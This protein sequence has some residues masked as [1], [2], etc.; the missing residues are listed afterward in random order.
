M[1]CDAPQLAVE[2]TEHAER[3][4]AI[5]RI[6]AAAGVQLGGRLRTEGL[7]ALEQLALSDSSE[8][9]LAAAARLAACSTPVE[10]DWNEQVAD[11]LAGTAQAGMVAR[12][13]VMSIA[14]AGDLVEAERRAAGLPNDAASAETRLRISQM[15][16]RPAA[17]RKAVKRLLDVAPDASSRVLAATTLVTAGDWKRA[18]ELATR[19]AYDPEAPPR[20]RADAFVTLLRTLADQGLWQDADRE[21]QAFRDLSTQSLGAGDGR[22]SAW[23]ARILHHRGDRAADR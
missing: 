7:D 5:T 6:R 4:D 12:L 13:H 3:R 10:A 22:V 19:V 14:C 23:Q 15:G 1:R 2:L 8:R 16:G 21:W 11:V 9:A 17:I 20:V 18:G